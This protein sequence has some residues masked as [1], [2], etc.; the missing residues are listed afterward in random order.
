MFI[1][2]NDLLVKEVVVIPLVHRANVNAFS[3]SITGYELTPW[4]SR[5]WDIMNWKRTID[6]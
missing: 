2:M 4:D 6:N 1:L 3:N 5:T